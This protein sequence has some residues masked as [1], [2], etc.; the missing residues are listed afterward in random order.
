[1]NKFTKISATAL[2]ALFLTACD[3]PADKAPDAKP[4][5]QT[6]SASATA[7][8]A[9]TDETADYK[10]LVDWNK[11][12]EQTQL[13]A[14]QKFQQDLV[15]AVQAKDDKKVQEAIDTFNKSVQE[16]IASLDALNISADSVKAVKEQ[17]KN[18]LGL[19]SNLLVEQANVSLANPTPEQQKTY[20]EK[21]EK[22]RDAML[23]LQKQSVALEQKF[24]PAPA[25]P[26]AAPVAPAQE[27][28]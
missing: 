6:Q 20:M 1:M 14:Q 15:A 26:A 11:S 24:N 25:T 4:E 28:K 7:E 5:A 10:K 21:A 12:Q 9:K 18:V 27:S 13:Q 8:A 23:E 22:L 19:A 2:F 17:T 3:K 16:T